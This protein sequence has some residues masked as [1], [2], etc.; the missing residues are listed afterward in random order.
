M[1]ALF[2]P[3]A[4]LEFASVFQG[5]AVLQRGADVAVWGTTGGDHTVTLSLDG[6]PLAAAVAVAGAWRAYLPPQATSWGATLQASDGEGGS[7]SVRVKI[8]Q[9]VLCGGQSNMQMPVNHWKEG[10]FSAFNG[11]AE[12]N[13]AGRYTGKLMIMS[14]QTPFPKPTSPPWNGTA[15]P[16]N[17]GKPVPGCTLDRPQW[18]KVS[19]GP[20]GTLHG[21]SAVCWYTGKSLFEQ[22]G[23]RT[24]VG[25][26]AGSVGGSPIEFWLPE[27][28]VNN[29]VCGR[30]DP[31][32]DT[33]GAKNLTDSG[34]YKKL[35]L[36]FAP[37]TLGSV[38]WDQ[39]RT[40]PKDT[41]P[42]D[43]APEHGRTRTRRADRKKPL[44]P[45]E[46]H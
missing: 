7:A 45:P 15:C 23:G 17:D 8:G 44:R 27:G 19:P 43:T 31:P 30:D 12:A 3:V 22:L 46:T 16:Y 38:V 2:A 34:F 9:T 1:V 26:I 29:S 11:T 18:N 14:L 24:P 10:G 41:L 28:S 36:P 40:A 39:V 32:C 4:A 5:G 33:G 37:Y 35:I 13:A 20:N 25:L 21:F 42:K 6:K